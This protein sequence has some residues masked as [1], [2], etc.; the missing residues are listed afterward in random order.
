MTEIKREKTSE[1]LKRYLNYPKPLRDVAQQ[2]I[3]LLEEQEPAKS[4]DEFSKII[5]NM[6]NHIWDC[7]I[8]HPIFQDTV[9]DLMNA[10]IQAYGQVVK[11]GD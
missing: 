9:G 5:H 11:L 6:F 8:E 10:V 4:K 2:A 1:G 7:E 3:T